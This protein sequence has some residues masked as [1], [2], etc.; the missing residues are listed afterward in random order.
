MSNIT[1]KFRSNTG[2]ISAWEAARSFLADR[3]KSLL[4]RGVRTVIDAWVQESRSASRGKAIGFC[5]RCE[6][7]CRMEALHPKGRR[8]LGRVDVLSIT[9]VLCPSHRAG[10]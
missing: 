2:A 4:E 9:P 6:R 5:H 8:R 7:A 3:S 1:N 10:P